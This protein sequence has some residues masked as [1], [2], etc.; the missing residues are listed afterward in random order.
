MND[1]NP[2]ILERQREQ[3][4]IRKAKEGCEKGI[5]DFLYAYE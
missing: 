4:L 3:E 5:I 2:P 1:H